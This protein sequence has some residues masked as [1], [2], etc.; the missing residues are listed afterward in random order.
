MNTVFVKT[1]PAPPF[2]DREIL[3]YAGVKGDADEQTL[4]LIDT[5]K[6]EIKDRLSYKVCYCVLPVQIQDGVC[7]FSAFSVRSQTLAKRLLG[8]EKVAV[9]AATLGVEI[10]RMLLKYGKIAPVKAV[11][12]QA[13]GAERIESLCNAFCADLQ[14]SGA[15]F[16]PGYGDLPLQTQKELFA[17]LDCE[18]KIGLTL[19]ESLLMSPTKSVTA[20]VGLGRTVCATNEEKCHNCAKTDCAFRSEK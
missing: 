3:R 5:L 17:L 20:F 2:C 8:Y 11:L 13:I 16:S 12:L 1:Y 4:A 18:R 6:N 7:D 10:D 14:Y 19:T 15:R 9:F